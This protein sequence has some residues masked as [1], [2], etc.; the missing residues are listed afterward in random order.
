MYPELSFS[1]NWNGKL[2]CNCFTTIRLRNDARYQVGAKFIVKLKD[3]PFGIY[4]VKGVKV[5][6]LAQINDWIG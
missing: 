2:N 1:Y 4:E 6:K 3:V 5:I